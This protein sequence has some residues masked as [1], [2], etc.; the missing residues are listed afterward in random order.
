MSAPEPPGWDNWGGS[1][2]LSFPF[3]LKIEIWPALYKP[4]AVDRPGA[5]SFASA[6]RCHQWESFYPV[7]G[8]THLLAAF[9]AV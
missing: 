8:E 6:D 3:Q 1:G 7:A 2:L 4:Q 9:C 5:L